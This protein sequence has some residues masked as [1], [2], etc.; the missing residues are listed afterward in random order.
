MRVELANYMLGAVHAL[1]NT[2]A[3]WRRAEWWAAQERH[4]GIGAHGLN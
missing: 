3:E 2:K 4:D 1:L